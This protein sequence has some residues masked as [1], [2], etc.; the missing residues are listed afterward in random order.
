MRPGGIGRF[1]LGPITDE[2]FLVQA[3]AAFV[4]THSAEPWS[5]PDAVME[6]AL[7]RLR[8]ELASPGAVACSSWHLPEGLRPPPPD[9]SVPPE[10]RRSYNPTRQPGASIVTI[11]YGHRIRGDAQAASVDDFA[12]PLPDGPAA[13]MTLCE[14]S[15]EP[16]RRNRTVRPFPRELR[17]L[18]FH[19]RRLLAE[20]G[21]MLLPEGAALPEPLRELG[22]VE[23]GR[24]PDDLSGL[25]FDL[26]E[27]PLAV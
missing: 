9:P 1:D 23:C 3:E 12:R 16:L 8:R 10:R 11:A 25:S 24:L 5:Y 27:G 6:R 19:L 18:M 13:L 26:Y 15:H 21:F 14:H 17:D 7:V 20:R 4:A 2:H 22:W